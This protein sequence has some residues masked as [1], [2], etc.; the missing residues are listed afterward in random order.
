MEEI[1]TLEE[2]K[3][4]GLRGGSKIRGSIDVDIAKSA[5]QKAIRRGN[6]ELA[7]VMGLRLNEFMDVDGGKGKPIRSNLINR[8]P[9]IAGEDIGMGN[10]WT[11]KKIHDYTLKYFSKTDSRYD[12]RLI[13][14][15]AWMTLSEKSRLGS[16]MNAVFYQALSSPDYYLTLENLYP[17]ILSCMKD[18]EL[19]MADLPNEVYDLD[20]KILQPQDGWFLVRVFYLLKNA[21]S[22]HEKMSTFFYIRN[23]YNSENKYKIKRG[24]TMRKI[25][26]EPIY[27]VWNRMMD[28]KKDDYIKVLYEQFL[29]ENEKHI[30]LVLALIVFFFG[31]E[32]NPS[33]IEIKDFIASF[34]GYEKI[35]EDA[36]TK[37]VEIPDY[38]V[39]KH[40][41]KGRSKGKDSIDFA[42]EGSIVENES[43]WS[44]KWTHLKNIYVDFRKWCPKFKLMHGPDELLSIWTGKAPTPKKISNDW[45]FIISGRLSK[46]KRLSIMSDQT[47]RGQVLTSSYKKYVYIP[48]DENFVYK[49]PFDPINGTPKERQKLRML[50]FRFDIVR[51]FK[52][53]VIPGE[54]Y[55]DDLGH[56]WLRY[57]SLANTN[58]E[59]WIVTET[60]DKTS[61]QTIRVVDRKSMGILPLSYYSH[62]KYKVSMYLFGKCNLYC[63]FLL[64]YVLGVGDTGLYNVLVGEL[65]PFIIDIDDDTTKTEFPHCC[66]IFGR[67]PIA[68]T[69]EVVE[70]GVKNNKEKIKSY[71][72]EMKSQ[73][74]KIVEMGK[75]WSIEMDPEK[76]KKK[77]LNIACTL[78]IEL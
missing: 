37:I 26:S 13:D 73:I 58:P 32:V 17:E 35:K 27:M 28:L 29:D 62:D 6:F 31:D 39:D 53:R 22:V 8:L 68:E 64:L 42:V 61:E 18:L 4:N 2:P 77:I 1:I 30:Y 20:Q 15:I 12:D 44:K 36:M 21:S 19:K 56:L 76:L 40:T 49:G 60:F 52:C 72:I 75:V 14:C 46:E 45:D 71:L 38:A 65:G 54:I 50:K 74:P 34:G 47:I 10:L 63:H 66:S 9:V 43:E 48:T 25:A 78:K 41:R 3:F 11:V 70:E 16:H 55:M 51:F 67:M 24:K 5:F 23:L 69:I 7:C 59:E 33:K 57:P